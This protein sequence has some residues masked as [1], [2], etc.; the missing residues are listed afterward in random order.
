MS[1]IVK[2]VGGVQGP[3]GAQGPI[4]PAGPS[5]TT[6]LPQQGLST[7]G[8]QWW[9]DFANATSWEPNQSAQWFDVIADQEG[10]AVNTTFDEGR[11]NFNGT[12]AKVTF[13][14]V[15]DAVAENF[16]TGGTWMCWMRVDGMGGNDNGRPYDI[17]ENSNNH[18]AFVG[19]ESGGFC[20]LYWS[21]V[22]SVGAQRQFRT[23]ALELELGEIVHVA[24]VY[25]AA[26]DTN[27][28]TIYINKVPVGVTVQVSGSGVA[29]TDGA[30]PLTVGNH[31]TL[32]RGFDGFLQSMGFWSEEF[33]A[34]EVARVYDLQVVQF[35]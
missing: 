7:N 8:L 33:T 1:G 9:I 3:T 30:D 17:N 6:R 11:L 35:P 18:Y 16:L 15:G 26:N 13:D 19:D 29:V 2:V 27:V 20:R 28:P 22:F 32:G 21:H 10:A 31:G 24:V 25:S 4:G 34:A 12:T 14:P 5:V 23:T